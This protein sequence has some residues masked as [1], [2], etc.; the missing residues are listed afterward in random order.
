[1]KCEYQPIERAGLYI[2]VFFILL[3]TCDIDPHHRRVMEELNNLKTEVESI[4]S[5]VRRLQWDS[6]KE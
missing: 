3:S 6:S 2:M 4:D 1:M 5:S